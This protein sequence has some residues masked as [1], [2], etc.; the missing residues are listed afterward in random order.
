MMSGAAVFYV[1]GYFQL[2]ELPKYSADPATTGIVAFGGL[3]T[4]IG[5]FRIF[6]RRPAASPDRDPEPRNRLRGAADA[7]P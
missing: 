2:V 6:R 5:W 1:L 7:L 3:C 4:V